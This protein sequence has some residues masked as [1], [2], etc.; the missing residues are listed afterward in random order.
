MGQL[1]YPILRGALIHPA[2][3]EG[4]DYYLCLIT[5]PTTL[6][7]GQTPVFLPDYPTETDESGILK[8]TC[9]VSIPTGYAGPV[10]DYL[11][12]V[13]ANQKV[14]NVTSVQVT[15]SDGNYVKGNPNNRIPPVSPINLTPNSNYEPANTVFKGLYGTDNYFILM[16]TSTG[17][18]DYHPT[19][20][21]NN[22][23]KQFQNNGTT[24]Q[25]VLN[26]DSSFTEGVAVVGAV[27]AYN[28]QYDYSQVVDADGNNCTSYIIDWSNPISL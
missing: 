11:L 5:L 16:M 9:N 4:I 10:T 22:T 20:G 2:E 17:A 27:A 19:G 8:Y 24:L 14:K 23:F 25:G 26:Q 6:S 21:Y 13:Y 7:D 18:S 3:K 1:I 28:G 15:G 12:P